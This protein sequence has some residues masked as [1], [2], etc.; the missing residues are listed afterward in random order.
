MICIYHSRDLDGWTS[1]A[2][3]KLKYPHAKMIGYDYGQP[4]P[5]DEIDPQQS[6]IMADVSLA[7]QD[8][9]R[10]SD[11]LSARLTWID[12]HISAIKDYKEKMEGMLTDILDPSISACEATWKYIF[13]DK[14][15]PQSVKLLGEYD[16]WR[17]KDKNRWDTM[18]LPFQFGMRVAC[19]SVDTFPIHLFSDDSKDI[20]EMIKYG[21]IVL[22]Y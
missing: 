18:I 5:W 14:D 3:I 11:I 17:N 4:F 13:P 22:K 2:I 1:A 16:T 21:N 7:M 6:V 19:N 9:K 8:M 12:H 15:M 20:I 10:L